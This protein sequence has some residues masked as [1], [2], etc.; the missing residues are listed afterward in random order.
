MVL[1]FLL[2]LAIMQWLYLNS[3]RDTLFER[4]SMQDGYSGATELRCSTQRWRQSKFNDMMMEVPNML[5][6]TTLTLRGLQCRL[7]HVER[8]L[9]ALCH[10]AHTSSS[11]NSSVF[12]RPKPFASSLLSIIILSLSHLPLWKL[13]RGDHVFFFCSSK[14][15]LRTISLAVM[16]CNSDTS[17][18]TR[19]S[20]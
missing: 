2:V 12:L 19:T 13:E 1:A 3:I 11:P 14:L 20:S 18:L 15:F 10:L 6:T 8:C 17:V 9:T 4:A 5:L 7:A 16:A